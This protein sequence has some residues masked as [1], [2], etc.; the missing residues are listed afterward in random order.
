MIY[1]H[2]GVPEDKRY[3]LMM[4]E[5]W[6]TINDV[7]PSLNQHW[8][9]AYCCWKPYKCPQYLSYEVLTYCC[10]PNINRLSVGTTLGVR[11]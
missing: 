6:P 8:V 11:F 7:V 3:L 4:F 10:G 5:C 1:T 9:K 2:R